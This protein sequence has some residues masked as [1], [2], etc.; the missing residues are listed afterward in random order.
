[1]SKGF[2]SWTKN[3]KKHTSDYFLSRS[4]L[5]FDTASK[6]FGS[7]VSDFL[8]CKVGQAHR[9]RGQIGQLCAR[10]LKLSTCPI[11]SLE[12]PTLLVI[13]NK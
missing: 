7:F 12:L 10:P 9:T 2:W 1:M 11:L 13:L 4:G 6:I 5:S 8:S 3:P